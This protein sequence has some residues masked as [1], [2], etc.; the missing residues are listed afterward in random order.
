MTLSFDDHPPSAN[1]TYFQDGP[2]IA[3]GFRSDASERSILI[4]ACDP[5][6]PLARS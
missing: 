5:R 6:V 2:E 1:L 4:G 3:T